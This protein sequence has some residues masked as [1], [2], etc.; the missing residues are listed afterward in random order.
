[1]ESVRELAQR[2]N[3]LSSAEKKELVRL[4]PDLLRIDEEFLLARWR[5]AREDLECE[6][7]TEASTAI[8]KAKSH[9]RA[10]K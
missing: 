9:R 7:V 8:K 3:G 1:M 5:L 10:T 6:R 2:I 4:V